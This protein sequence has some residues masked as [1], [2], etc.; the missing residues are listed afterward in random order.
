LICD[1]PSVPETEQKY[2]TVQTVGSPES[3][4][5]YGLAQRPM[6]APGVDPEL[7]PR[8]LC[9]QPAQHLS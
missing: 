4:I 6:L 2:A 1:H 7:A 9:S 5:L 8:G 3:G